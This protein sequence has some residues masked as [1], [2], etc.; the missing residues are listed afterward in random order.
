MTN[1]TIH[2]LEISTISKDPNQ[3]RKHFD[4]DAQKELTESIKKHGV[5]TPILVRNDATEKIILVAGE[6]RL[7]SANEAGLDTIPAIFTTGKPAEIALVENLLREDLTALE[8]AYG[9]KRLQDE[10]NYTNNDIA[11]A[12]GKSAS[13]VSGTLSILKLPPKTLE[14]L[15]KHPKTP[16][17]IL[18]KIASL[19]DN[20]LMAGAWRRYKNSQIDRE[21]VDQ[22]KDNKGVRSNPNVIAHRFVVSASKSL[23]NFNASSLSDADREKMRDELEDLREKIQETLSILNS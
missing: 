9:L 12:L 22:N 13:T 3:P 2:Q 19:K 14:D 23:D 5:I 21:E 15:E 4:S 16:K 8:E 11:E 1:S 17:R 6:R 18:I 10:M 20:R 7:R